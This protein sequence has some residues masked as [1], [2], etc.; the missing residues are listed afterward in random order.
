MQTEQNYIVE[1]SMSTLYFLSELHFKSSK[2]VQEVLVFQT[3][4]KLKP[5]CYRI[6]LNTLKHIRVLSTFAV[7]VAVALNQYTC[8]SN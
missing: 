7:A 6:D 3:V 8:V 5:T 1:F 2:N 4:Y